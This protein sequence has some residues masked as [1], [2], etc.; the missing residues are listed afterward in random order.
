MKTAIRWTFLL[1]LCTVLVPGAVFA[2]LRDD[3]EFGPRLLE[4]GTVIFDGVEFAPGEF[5]RPGRALTWVVTK[6]DAENGTIHAF[7]SPDVAGVFMN[8]V[9]D[10]GFG[11]DRGKGLKLTTA[12]ACT[13]TPTTSAFNKNPNCTSTTY[14]Y[15]SPGQQYTQLD[16]ISWNNSISCVKA[17]CVNAWT[18]IYSC[19]DFQLTYEAGVCDDPNALFVYPGVIAWD[20]NNTTPEMNN[21]T[22]SIRFCPSYPNCF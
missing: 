16:S 12:A 13:Y 5:E 7:S 15:M 17:A 21:R 9:M 4:R 8:R 10:K 14:I 20:L 11:K 3:A 6:E 18:T 1:A 19:R 22:S 2:Q